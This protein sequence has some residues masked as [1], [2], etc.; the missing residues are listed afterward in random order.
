ML[1]GMHACAALNRLYASLHL[2]SFMVPVA[3]CHVSAC[4]AQVQEGW[5][6]LVQANFTRK[7]SLAF[8]LL[9]LLVVGVASRHLTTLDSEDA[10][11]HQRILAELEEVHKL[12]ERMLQQGATLDFS[13]VD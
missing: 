2:T 4:H 7:A 12:R 11:E 9:S 1:L 13:A 3:F 8:L 10:L 5:D 6:C